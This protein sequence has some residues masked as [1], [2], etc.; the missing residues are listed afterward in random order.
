MLLYGPEMLTIIPQRRYVAVHHI[1]R[2]Y[3]ASQNN[4]CLLTIL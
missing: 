3:N 4:A 1:V 2:E